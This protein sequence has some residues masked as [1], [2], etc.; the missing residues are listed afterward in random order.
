MA[1]GELTKAVLMDHMDWFDPADAEA[2]IREVARAVRRGGMVLWRSAGRKP[3]Y[4]ALFEKHGFE[5]EAVGV[6]VPGS[7]VSID[8]VNMYASCYKAI[9][10]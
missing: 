10:K 7:G 3:W 2:E 4:N 8:R 6:R 5:V 9:R 1:D